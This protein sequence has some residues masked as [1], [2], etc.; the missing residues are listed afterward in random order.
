MNIF[1]VNSHVFDEFLA[2]DNKDIKTCFVSTYTPNPRLT[3]RIDVFAQYGGVDV[4]CAR[5]RG[6]KLWKVKQIQGVNYII[7]KT[8]IKSSTDLIGRLITS[9]IFQ[10]KALRYLRESQPVVI[11]CTGFDSLRSAYKFKKNNKAKIVYEV[12][13]LRDDFLGQNSSI[14]RRVIGHKLVSLERRYIKDISLMVIT[15]PEFF[16]KHYYKFIDRSNV[17]FI[18]NIPKQSFFE[19][20]R[21]KDGGD[22]TI[23]FIGGIRYLEQMK[24]MVDAVG[25]AGCNGFFAGGAFEPDSEREL[26]KY[27]SGKSNIS[28]LGRYDYDKDI[29]S[30]YGKADCI[31]AVYDADNA[32]VRMALPNKLYE[33]IVCELPIIVAKG[34][35][36]A[37][38][39]EKLGVGVAVNHK[40]AYECAHEISRL[41]DGT[42]FYESIVENCRKICENPDVLC[43][44][45]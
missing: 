17:L 15:S 44:M 4:V 38:V 43:E 23:G 10:N 30:L 28:I 39:V 27:C 32:N 8:H 18:P 40:D 26:R 21:H 1:N 12:S 42:F 36:L 29:A 16:N 33:A 11:Y 3:K 6:V 34:T 2:S 22:F 37:Y 20:Y 14:I 25:I 13:D 45:G 5:R 31:Y 7:L 24:L 19:N 41:R 9:F 35:Y